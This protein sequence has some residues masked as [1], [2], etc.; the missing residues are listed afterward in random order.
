[1]LELP[2]DAREYQAT[3][4][5]EADELRTQYVTDDR[6]DLAAWSRDALALEMPDKILCRP[7]CAGL[8]PVCGKDLNDEP[9]THEDVSIDSRWSSLEQL[10]EH[11]S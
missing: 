1:V 6:L 9:H 8:C 4:P 7:D 3:S 11:L 5:G 10:R 2:I